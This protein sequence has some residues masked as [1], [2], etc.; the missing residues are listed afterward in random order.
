MRDFDYR[1]YSNRIELV[2]IFFKHI[3]QVLKISDFS[4]GAQREQSTRR[5]LTAIISADVHGYSRPM[6]EDEETGV[7]TLSAWRKG[8]GSTSSLTG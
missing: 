2:A 1:R 4:G 8:F 5:K 3:V 6:G 7:E